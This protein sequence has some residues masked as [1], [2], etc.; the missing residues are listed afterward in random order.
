MLGV[1][2]VVRNKDI[3]SAGPEYTPDSK[4]IRVIEEYGTNL[5]KQKNPTEL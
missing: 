5:P 2:T 4:E 3:A 1:E